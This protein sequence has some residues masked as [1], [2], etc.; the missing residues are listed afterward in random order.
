MILLQN[1]TKQYGELIAVDIEKLSV[2]NGRIFSF[3]G[4]NGA[5]KTT[6][7]KMMLGILMPTGG[8]VYIDGKNMHIQE[9]AIEVKKKMAY[10]ADTPLVYESLTGRE[11]VKFISS[12]YDTAITDELEKE[13][14]EWFIKFEMFDKLDEYIGGYSHGTQ[15]KVAII[16]ALVHKPQIVI[17]DEPTVGL[18]PQSIKTLKDVLVEFAEH[19][20]LV[21]L[22]THILSIAEE[23][24]DEFAII[25]HGKI[26]FQG[27]IEEA[28]QAFGKSF[29]LEELF[30]YL[31]DTGE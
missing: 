9:E 30:I 31:T 19:G 20:G 24:S 21:F 17:L 23:I 16:A 29:N 14:E 18:D 27:N 4:K 2:R 10:I 13:I 1:I 5:G 3:I 15:Q 22:S 12:L 11:Y 8:Y 7:I 6:T 26:M 25:D 28:K